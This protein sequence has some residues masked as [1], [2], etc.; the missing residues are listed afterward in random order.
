M[1][2]FSYGHDASLLFG[3]LETQLIP[4]IIVGYSIRQIVKCGIHGSLNLLACVCAIGVGGG[5]MY[6]CL[7]DLF[8]LSVSPAG[9]SPL[10]ASAAIV[11]GL[12]TAV[13]GACF[14]AVLFGLIQ[15]KNAL[16]SVFILLTLTSSYE[17]WLLHVGGAR[18]STLL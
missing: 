15:R 13:T 2:R 4:W 3:C 12:M 16:S 9:S 7:R 18:W 11:M 1:D 14:L 8:I 10:M 17:A 6:L 5:T